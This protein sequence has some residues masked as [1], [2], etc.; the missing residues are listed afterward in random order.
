MDCRAVQ[1]AHLALR[2]QTGEQHSTSLDIQGKMR[3]RGIRAIVVRQGKR[4]SV[5][6]W[7]L[8]GPFC[9]SD[10]GLHPK[11]AEDWPGAGGDGCI[12][13]DLV[14]LGDLSLSDP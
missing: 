11:P 10:K 5:P 2:W 4:L 9:L 12:R 6:R 14:T 1:R 13:S 7:W 8:L 3:T